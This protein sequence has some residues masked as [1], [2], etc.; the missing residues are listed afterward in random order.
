MSDKTKA[1]KEPNPDYSKAT[2]DQI[3]NVLMAMRPGQPESALE[4]A[5][6]NLPQKEEAQKEK[7]KEAEDEAQP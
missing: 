1:V 6:R 2:S 4:E 5:I 7:S 3:F